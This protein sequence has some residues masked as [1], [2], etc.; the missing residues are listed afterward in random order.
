MIALPGWLVGII[1]VPAMFLAWGAL[2]AVLRRVAPSPDGDPDVLACRTCGKGA[3]CRG[4]IHAGLD[5]ATGED[6]R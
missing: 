1:V 2:L 3:G 4:C 6:S 5:A